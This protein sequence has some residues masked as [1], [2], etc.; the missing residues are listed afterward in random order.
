MLTG[1]AGI[2]AE[3]A[4]ATSDPPLRKTASD[5]ALNESERQQGQ[6]DANQGDETGP[7]VAIVKNVVAVIERHPNCESC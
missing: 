3:G 7:D 6:R 2:A 1:A 4:E 5:I